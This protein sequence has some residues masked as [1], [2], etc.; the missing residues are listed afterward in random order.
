MWTL[1][2][3]F[4]SQIDTLVC[5]ITSFIQSLSKNNFSIFD[6][7]SITTK[8]QSNSDFKNANIRTTV[9]SE[10]KSKPTLE[11]TA[12]SIECD[13][14]SQSSTYSS[15]S[16]TDRYVRSCAVSEFDF[17][18]SAPTQINWESQNLVINNRLNQ[19][20]N[21]NQAHQNIKSDLNKNSSADNNNNPIST[22]VEHKSLSEQPQLRVQQ[23]HTQAQAQAQ[24]YNEPV[25]ADFLLSQ[26]NQSFQY[27]LRT[28]ELSQ[29]YPNHQSLHHSVSDAEGDD[30]EL[31]DDEHGD[32]IVPEQGLLVNAN[33]N[34]PSLE[35]PKPELEP[36]VTTVYNKSSHL[37]ASKT[38][39]EYEYPFYDDHELPLDD[40]LFISF[41]NRDE[42]VPD[43]NISGFPLSSHCDS[44]VG[45]GSNDSAFVSPNSEA[46]TIISLKRDHVEHNDHNLESKQMRKV[47][48]T[49]FS[50]KSLIIKEK[51]EKEKE[52]KSEKNNNNEKLPFVCEFCSVGFK[53][54][55]YLTRHIKKHY[56]S[57]P[58]KCPYFDSS[59]HME[60]DDHHQQHDDDDNTNTMS[61]GMNTEH[62]SDDSVSRCH[63]TGGFSRRDTLNTHLKALHFIYPSG[64]RSV[65]RDK[66][67]GRCAA[68]FE[69]F[70]N[71]KEWLTN[72]IMANKCGLAITEYK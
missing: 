11:V 60:S 31:S 26:F 63:I 20:V 44:S 54:K 7:L 61:D 66:K 5:L 32:Y 45:F 25:N 71:N 39:L 17:D 4:H 29:F 23:R 18:Y 33:Y 58:F 56:A 57:K 38:D 53:V 1:I 2:T 55:G 52:D 43:D 3:I 6:F 41:F 59:K 40:E 46:S 65:D 37:P 27:Q 36:A 47:R 10:P 16:S 49:S 14:F 12:A 19:S 28:T 30:A 62:G 22:I 34:L 9:K 48:K 50:G 35:L 68:C 24:Q 13:L 21:I 42:K 64:T 70:R 72:H 51:V 15:F 69:E 8:P 67:S